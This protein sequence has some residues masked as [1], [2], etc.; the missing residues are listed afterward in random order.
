MP[1]TRYRT[2]TFPL[3]ILLEMCDE[4]RQQLKRV[5]ILRQIDTVQES[6]TTVGRTVISI[7]RLYLAE[8]QDE[9]GKMPFWKK[10]ENE[11]N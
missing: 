1:L 8:T 10:G 7:F 2:F 5:I 4:K 11:K 6:R 3:F 9:R